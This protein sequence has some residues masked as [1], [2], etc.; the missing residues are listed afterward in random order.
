MVDVVNDYG[1]HGGLEEK[2]EDDCVTV[3][4]FSSVTTNSVK[5]GLSK[6]FLLLK[7]RLASKK[8]GFRTLD[9]SKPIEKT[10]EIGEFYGLKTFE[11]FYIVRCSDG[12]GAKLPLADGVY[13]VLTND[14]SPRVIAKRRGGG[15]LV[16][17]LGTKLD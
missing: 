7:I 12:K 14:I 13:V 15:Y 8:Y 9:M 10:I 17:P 2:S 16:V 4:P 5:N 3:D 1:D 11:E 6:K